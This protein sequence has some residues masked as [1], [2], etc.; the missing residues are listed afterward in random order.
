MKFVIIDA[1]AREVKTVECETLQD[2]EALAGL[3]KGKVDHGSI[4]RNIGYVVD[5]HGLFKPIAE[6]HYFVMNSR[7]VAGNS[8]LYAYND[9]GDTIDMQR[10][11][12]IFFLENRLEVIESAFAKGICHRPQ[13]KIN[14]KIIWQW[15]EPEVRYPK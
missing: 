14:D 4:A 13:L 6:Q 15:P 7:L 11:P 3:D 9:L 12:M 1:T 5:E 10:A 8:V 2:A